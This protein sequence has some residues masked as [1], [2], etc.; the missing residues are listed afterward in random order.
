MKLE[1][2]Q[3]EIK[4]QRRPSLSHL[5]SEREK[6][7]EIGAGE[8]FVTGIRCGNWVT[9]KLQPLSMSIAVV[10]LTF[11]IWDRHESLRHIV[12]FLRLNLD[13]SEDFLG[14][15]QPIKRHCLRNT[16][17]TAWWWSG[18]A[19]LKISGLKDHLRC[20]PIRG[21]C[22]AVL[23]NQ[24]LV[25]WDSSNERLAWRLERLAQ[26]GSGR[27]RGNEIGRCQRQAQVIRVMERT[28][29]KSLVI[30]SLFSIRR[31]QLPIIYRREPEQ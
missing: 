21:L 12:I 7:L 1:L 22:W 13:Q 14:R 17:L 2:S 23:T 26:G 18:G 25:K 8:D 31:C 16:L 30:V 6:G 28:T 19:P 24:K 11:R 27:G 3:T 15:Q 29:I 10:F 4:D 9:T 20:Q 5:K